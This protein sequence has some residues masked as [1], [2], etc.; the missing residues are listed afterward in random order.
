MKWTEIYFQ[1][2]TYGLFIMLGIL[3]A[4]LLYCGVLLIIAKIIQKQNPKN[5][6]GKKEQQ[7]EQTN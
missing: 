3:F 2:Q 6:K 1:I 5:K 4:T 7:N